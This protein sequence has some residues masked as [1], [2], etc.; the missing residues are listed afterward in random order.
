MI[1]IAPITKN[2]QY[3]HFKKFNINQYQLP[4]APTFYLIDFK[5]QGQTFEQLIINLH[6]PPD[7]VQLNMHNIYM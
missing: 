2:F 4:L 3:H 7:I 6:Q 5:F 1:L